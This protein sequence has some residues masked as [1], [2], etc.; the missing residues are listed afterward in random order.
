MKF[1]ESFTIALRSLFANKLRSSLTML[2]IIIGVSAVIAIM[3]G[4]RG[5]ENYVTSTLEDMGTDILYVTPS[6]PNAPGAAAMAPGYATATLTLDDAEAI[7]RI[8]SV[9]GVAPTNENFVEL[10]FGDETLA[11]V[12]EGT[13]PEFKDL[14]YDIAS[15]QFITE[16]NVASR[17]M[18]AV[19]GSET[20]KKLFSDEDPLGQKIKIN[21]KRFTVVGVLSS[22]GGAMFGF[23]LDEIV[24]V[25]ITT[26]QTRL[27]PQRTP[28]GEDAVQSIGVI[29]S[30]PE[31]MDNVTADIE[32]TL[33]NRHRIDEDEKDDFT[34]VSMEQMIGAF[35]DITGVVSIFLAAIA[36]IG[37]LVASIGIMNIMLVSVTERTREIGIRKAVGA[38]RRDI[39]L[40]FLLEAAT[41]SLIGGGAGIAFGWAL[42]L[43]ISIIATLAGFPLQATLSP[44]HVIIAV[45][46]SVFIGLASGIY[47]AM[48][49]ARLN[50]IDA[51][52]YE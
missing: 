27:F 12:I 33:R 49:A 36:S 21:E 51:L 16:R 6:N 28:G 29:V 5:M 48:R 2:G 35:S 25:P 7:A 34:I 17:D 8:P 10:T 3:A 22:K 4:G 11:S 44:L 24:A 31:A 40:Q 41:L 50:P 32:T 26:Y 42:S 38:K 9:L 30:G 52:H 20:A 15:G 47:P 18:V 39:L 37:L 45:G 46:V 19:L 1:I 23:S 43:V 14:G 13:T